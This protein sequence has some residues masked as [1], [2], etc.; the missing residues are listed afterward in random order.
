MPI[1]SSTRRTKQNVLWIRRPH[2]AC[3]AEDKGGSMAF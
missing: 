3:I 2:Q 1:D